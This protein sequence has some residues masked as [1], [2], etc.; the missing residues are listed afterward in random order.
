MFIGKEARTYKT[1]RAV[2]AKSQ[3]M[4]QDRLSPAYS[5][6]LHFSTNVA[7]NVS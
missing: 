7:T 4:Q 2:R 6:T 1:C 5:S 3:P